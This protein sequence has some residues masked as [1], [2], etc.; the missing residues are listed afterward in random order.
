MNDIVLQFILENLINNLSMS[1]LPPKN[2]GT[3]SLD[4]AFRSIIS[5][6]YIQK[7]DSTEILHDLSRLSV[8]EL[9]ALREEI[10][11]SMH[12]NGVEM[13]INSK[14]GRRVDAIDQLLNGRET[15]QS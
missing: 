12:K 11:E 6:P 4:R 7:K 3:E 2:E 5:D 1:E 13:S 9:V 8:D 10:L 15:S 14:D